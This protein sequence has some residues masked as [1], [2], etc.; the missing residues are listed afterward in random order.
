MKSDTTMNQK[1]K[2][3]QNFNTEIFGPKIKTLEKPARGK[4]MRKRRIYYSYLRENF[5]T[6]I[7]FRN[8]NSNLSKKP[9]HKT[10]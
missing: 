8:T 3:T 2:H 5:L 6:T 9:S 1:I 4:T 10:S 7:I